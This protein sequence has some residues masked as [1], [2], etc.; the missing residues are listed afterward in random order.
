MRTA[1]TMTLGLMFLMTTACSEHTGRTHDHAAGADMMKKPD[2]APEMKKLQRMVGR[3]TGTAEM[4]EPTREE[5]AKQMPE[6]EQM[7]DMK[8]AGG[9]TT[10]WV[11]EGHFLKSEGWHEMGPGQ[12]MNMV[13][14]ITWDAGVGKYRSYWFS[15]W[16]EVGE[17]TMTMS[18]D[19]N[20]MTFKSEGFNAHGERSKGSGTMKFV[21]NNTIEW[22]WTEKGPEGTMKLKGTSRRQM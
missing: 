9:G 16:G 17:G 3:W 5:M 14:Y 12:R 2:P 13:E 7:G 6:G 21:N 1:I 11:M 10:D 8:F 4:I 15:D 19:G 18:A 22:T 20:T